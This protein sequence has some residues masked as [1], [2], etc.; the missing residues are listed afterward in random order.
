M[1]RFF[2]YFLAIIITSCAQ[3]PQKAPTIENK[4]PQESPKQSKNAEDNVEVKTVVDE[5]FKLS[6]R[7]N[8]SFTKKVPIEFEVI[9]I[10]DMPN[11]VGL[12][13]SGLDY[14]KITI[15][16]IYWQYFTWYTKMV[17]IYHEMTHCYCGR[18]HDYGDGLLYPENV[19]KARIE[20]YNAT[21]DHMSNHPGYMLDGCPES[22]MFP[23]VLGDKCFK[24]HYSHYVKEMF[25][26]CNPW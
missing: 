4:P 20:Q 24:E 17:M 11:A 7:Y 21:N 18:D 5:Y 9:K 6:A 13:S 8:L 10:K 26:R 3:P 14:R 2:T 1:R 23:L 22:V 25:D 19:L 16:P 15:D 12:C